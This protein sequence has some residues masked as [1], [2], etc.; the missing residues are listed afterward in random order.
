MI[1]SIAEVKKLLNK[2]KI[3]RAKLGKSIVHFTM[4]IFFIIMAI[5]KITG[6]IIVMMSQYVLKKITPIKTYKA[7][8]INK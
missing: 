1:S 4:I 5:V 6:Q 7:E 3:T 8:N 2:L